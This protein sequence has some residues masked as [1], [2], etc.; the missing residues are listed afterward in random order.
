MR[1]VLLVAASAFLVGCTTVGTEFA[2]PEPAE[3]M[4]GQTTRAEIL[5]RYGAPRAQRTATRTLRGR[6]PEESG[7]SGTFGEI[8][9]V[10]T[11]RFEISG[12]LAR[13]ELV[14]IFWNDKLIGYR[15]YS[16]FAGDNSSFDETRVPRIEKNKTTAS[17]AIGLL[18][19][20]T[21]MSIYPATPSEKVRY[22][23]YNY[24][25]YDRAKHTYLHKRLWL[26]LNSDD[27]VIDHRF[28]SQTRP[29]S[30]QR[31]APIPIPI[32]IPR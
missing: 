32:F 14:F 1:G 10:Y 17:E 24:L 15:F 2:R 7:E 30:P 29:Y 23:T 18:G 21:G 16:T 4:L 27:V 26:F 12:I 3:L 9:Y 19:A 8:F 11:N 22:L 31:P 20:P 5:D 28:E 13:K 6:S 25:E